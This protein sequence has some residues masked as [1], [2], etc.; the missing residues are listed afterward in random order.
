M[1]ARVVGYARV[2]VR[3]E[4]VEVQVKAIEAYAEEHGLELVGVF[5]DEAVTG[6]SNPFEREAFQAMYKFCRDNG[7]NTVLIYDLTRLG[8]SLIAAV[9]AL[10]RLLKEGFQVYFI[11]HNIK[12]DLNDPAS[13]VMIYTLLMVAE[14]ERDF[15]KMRQEEAW[16]QGKIKGRPPKVSDQVII[17]YLRKYGGLSKKAIWKIMVGDGLNLSY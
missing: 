9:E 11:R 6:A 2:S 7:V 13:K 3:G 15:M 4:D 16:R 12:A 5:R 10:R 17:K 8:R 1:S 14:L